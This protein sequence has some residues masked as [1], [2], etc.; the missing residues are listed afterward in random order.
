MVV[1][2]VEVALAVGLFMRRTHRWLLPIGILFHGVMVV[3]LPVATFSVT[4]WLLYLAVLDPDRVHAF[5]D[6]LQAPRPQT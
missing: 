3:T 1:L 6:G 2:L 5:M 4:M